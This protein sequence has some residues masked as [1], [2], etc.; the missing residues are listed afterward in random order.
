[1]TLSLMTYAVI[2]GALVAVAAEALHTGAA[3]R[4]WPTRFVWLAAI[5]A[6]LIWPMTSLLPSA[7][8]NI[9]ASLLPFTVSLPP[10]RVTARGTA[11]AG[12]ASLG[13]ALIIGWALASALLLARFISDVLIVRRARLDWPVQQIDGRD[14]RLTAD[15]GPA[16]VGLRSMEL[17]LPQWIFSLDEPLRALV[18][19]HEEEHR[20]AGDP[21]LLIVARLATILMPWNPAVWYATRRVRLAIEL[22]CDARVLRAHPTPQRYGMLLLTIAQRRTSVPTA[23]SP[24]LSESTTQLER[25]IIAMQPVHRRLARLTAVAA[26][27]VAA[28]ALAFACSVHP[29]ATTAPRP[30]GPTRAT[31]S[32]EGGY[33]EFQVE[34]R[35][36]PLP[37]S[38]PPRYPDELRKARIEGEVVAEF[39]VDTSGRVDPTTFKVLRSSHSLFTE[40]VRTGLANMKFSPAEVGGRKVKELI[41][42]P[43]NFS[44]QEPIPNDTIRKP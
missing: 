26:P 42:M 9:G 11:L 5:V 25:R 1:M 12:A 19:R 8:P 41:E 15:I 6:M 21:H 14:V 24:M 27:L 16:V 17:V 31:T 38:A 30:S 43:F 4:G 2:V 22:D 36:V 33:F 44:L 18:L 3:S 13:D 23:F 28:G 10:L 37:G 32:A 35:A 20:A 40:T 7:P 39:V 29:E 34:K